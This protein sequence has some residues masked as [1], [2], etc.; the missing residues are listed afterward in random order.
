MKTTRESTNTVPMRSC[1][2][3]RAPSPKWELLRHV[4]PPI[5][6]DTRELIPDPEQTLPGRGY[7]VCANETCRKRF[8]RY[9]GWRRKCKG[10]AHDG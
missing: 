7:Y 2:I 5:E 1:V 9:S 6:G 10:V 4:C 3:C 8:P